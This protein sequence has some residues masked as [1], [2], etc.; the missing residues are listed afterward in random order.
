MDNPSSPPGYG[1]RSVAQMQIRVATVED[2]QSVSD[3]VTHIAQEQIALTLSEE[4]L[5]H[6]IAGMSVANQVQRLREGYRFFIAFD[7]DQILGIA[8]VRL[9]FH[10]YYLFVR[11]DQQRK[12]IGRQLWSH[13]R[14]SICEINQNPVIT[15]NSSLNAVAVYE[16]LGFRIEGPMRESH[17]VRFQPM[18]FDHATEPSDGPESPTGLFFS[19]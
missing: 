9:P 19:G 18:R 11:P 7:R 5:K 2:A 1:G 17:G 13:A 14:D 16:R 4:G 15:V 12:G 6:L 8:C 10:L 3:F